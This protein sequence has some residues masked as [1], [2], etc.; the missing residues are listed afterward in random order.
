MATAQP[1]PSSPSI[2]SAGTSTS[3]KKTSQNSSRPWIASIGRTEMPGESMSTN[4]AVMPRCPESGPPVRVS[5]THRW[6]Y[7]AK[8]VHTFWPVTLQPSSVRT[9]AQARAAR[10]LPV[11]GSEKPWHQ[12]SSPRSRRGTISAARSGRA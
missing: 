9:A 4:S 5:S 7:W 12:V 6:A 1:C 8:L 11:P 2:R 10:L 3:S